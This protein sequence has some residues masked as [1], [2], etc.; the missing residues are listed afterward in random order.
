M[1]SVISFHGLFLLA[2]FSIQSCSAFVSILPEVKRLLPIGHALKATLPASSDQ[3]IILDD[4]DAV[5][6][7]VREIVQAAAKTAILEKGKFWLAIPGGSILKMLVGSKGD[8]TAKTSIAYVNHKCVPMDDI[9][10]ATHAKAMKLFMHEWD[11][12]DPILLDGTDNSDKE[13]ASY[14]LKLK[15]VPLSSNGLPCFDLALIGV[16]DDGHIGSL[17]PNR[18][19]VL[20][21]EAWVLSVPMKSPPSITLSLPL[22]TNAKQVIVAA[23]GV[24]DKYPQGKSL[25]MR[26]AIVDPEE[27]I[28]S[29][30]AVALRQTATWI[31]DKAAASKLGDNYQN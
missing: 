11:G 13:A 3:V 21:E 14:Q 9:A 26:R 4:A 5:G 20:E 8:W 10:L 23:C 17:Y 2:S 22:M 16:G 25:G 29:F 1:Y 7:R 18:S 24:S 31:M 15:N 30:P 6:T 28:Q 27:T 12:C 19:E